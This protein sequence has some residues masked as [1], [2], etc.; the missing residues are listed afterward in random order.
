MRVAMV[1]RP[2]AA[3]RP[4]G[5]VV[6]AEKTAEALRRL[7][8]ST[9]LSS[10][11]DLAAADVVHV[12]NLQTADWTLGQVRAARA[13]RKPVVLS[14]I[15]W[16]DARL[17]WGALL[18]MGAVL[19]HLPAAARSLPPSGPSTIPLLPA[20]HRKAAAQVL[21]YADAIL[22]NSEAEARHLSADF[23]EASR[24]GAPIIPV[25]NG[26]D[27]EA[28]DRVAAEPPDPIL[29]DLPASFVLC[30]SRIDYRKNTLALI[31][32]TRR[33]RLPLVVAGAAVES[34]AWHRAYVAACQARG[35]HVRFLG[36]L[37]QDRLWSLYRA[38]A[39]HALPS[40]FETPG[41]SSLEAGLAGA[42]IVTT[43]NGSTREYFG[44]RARYANALSVRSI[45]AAIGHSLAEPPPPDLPALVREKY[46]WDRAAAITLD[47]YRRVL[48][49]RPS[50]G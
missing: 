22:P 23:P 16:R 40:F 20:M 42:R 12:F 48:G 11:D 26:V 25:P 14:P 31:E 33:L 7:G 19:P 47:A 5:D 6:Q 29:R 27:V 18:R 44:E 2:D 37:P 36:P 3:A 1:L 34:T 21:A 13:L 35:G 9:T 17:P 30:A 50:H 8:V 45:A 41:L 38:C 28:F 43:P 15:Y 46:T 4:G 49:G 10:G 32:A 24:A 39:V